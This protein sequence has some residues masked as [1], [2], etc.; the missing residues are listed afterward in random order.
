MKTSLRATESA[1]SLPVQ[2]FTMGRESKWANDLPS[3]VGI[4]AIVLCV[5]SFV[6]PVGFFS[7]HDF[8]YIRKP[9]WIGNG[10]VVHSE[11]G[12]VIIGSVLY[13]Y[14]WAEGDPYVPPNRLRDRP[15]ISVWEWNSDYKPLPSTLGFSCSDEYW[16]S[17]GF[18]DVAQFSLP[19]PL[20][21]VIW[22]IVFA[23]CR[24]LVRRRRG[25]RLSSAG[26]CLNCGYDLRA[27]RE[28]CPECGTPVGERCQMPGY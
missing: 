12:V 20:L 21:G 8:Y 27:S 3:F 25:Q 5:V 7:V 17:R 11:R 10:P 15:S 18:S 22:L 19:L 4:T 2:I 14:H 16:Q 23:E 6:M 26:C 13:G 1:C 28:R 9:A 24:S